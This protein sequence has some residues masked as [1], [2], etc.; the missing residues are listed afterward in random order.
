MADGW[1]AWWDWDL[2]LTPHVE[3]RM[4]QR[5]LSE[6]GLRTLFQQAQPDDLKPDVVEDRWL[7][8]ASL[9]RERWA[10]IVE[11]DHGDSVLVVVT[12]YKVE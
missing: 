4:E 9:D 11:P 3:K 2:E 6:V 8:T 1:P 5:G 7:V 10:I 12:V